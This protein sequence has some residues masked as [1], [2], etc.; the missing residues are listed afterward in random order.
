M[1]TT[2]IVRPID[3]LGRIVL[4][5]E[6]RKNLSLEPRDLLEIFLEDGSIV[7]KKHQKSCV[8]CKNEKNLTQINGKYICKDCMFKIKEKSSC[9]KV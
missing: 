1:Q 2:G 6:L 5:I 4:P 3:S 8:F 9:C 7:L